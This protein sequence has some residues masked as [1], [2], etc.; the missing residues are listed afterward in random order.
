[1]D[2]PWENVGISIQ[3]FWFLLLALFGSFLFWATVGVLDIVSIAPGEVVPI[4]K[5]QQVQHL[6]GGI[7]QEILVHEGDIVKKDQPLVVLDSIASRTDVAS[8]RLQI[9][10][11]EID[12]HRLQTE[13]SGKGTLTFPQHFTNTTPASEEKG[14]SG[15]S[16]NE[17]HH[18]EQLIEQATTLFNARH[19]ALLSRQSAQKDELTQRKQGLAEIEARLN[20]QKSRLTLLQEQVAISSK[21]LAT[22]TTSR[23]EH[24]NLLKESNTLKS[25]IEED[26]AGFKQ[27][28]AAV[29]QAEEALAAVWNDFANEIQAQLK[30]TQHALNDLLLRVGKF[31]DN[32]QRTVLRSP[33]DGVIKTLYAVSRGGVIAP[34]G[35][36]LDI[37]PGGDRL[38]VEA[39][40]PAQDVG[41]VHLGQTVILRL[42]SAEAARFGKLEGIVNHIG[43]DTLVNQ[44]GVPY[45]MVRITTEQSYFQKGTDRYSL[46]PGVVVSAGILT[47]Q[48][49]VM[50]YFLGPFMSGMALALSER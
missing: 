33:I 31:E 36:V 40:L 24:L 39:H 48:R 42:A 11:L 25:Q 49:T 2:E 4:S 38:I 23:Y 30:E 1:M 12:L 45:Y 7:V 50:E 28:Q 16:T 27:A 19:R 44:E 26:E 5:V 41:H 34:G 29:R 3:L 35:T 22:K 9:R 17:K 15:F 10:A 21:M 20:N 18:K 13:A 6:E 32:E 47:G 8:M 43:P 37:V 46:V 14:S